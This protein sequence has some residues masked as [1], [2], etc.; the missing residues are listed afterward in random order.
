MTE[1]ER[2]V[3]ERWV[4]ERWGDET[5]PIPVVAER[6]AEETADAG[7]DG[8][9]VALSIGA[10]ALAGLALILLL[11][12]IGLWALYLFHDQ[13]A[14]PAPGAAPIVWT[15]T[16]SAV[17]TATRPPASTETPPPTLAPALEVGQYVQVIQ[18]G[19]Y[20]LNLRAGPG[21]DHEIVRVASDGEIFLAIE[22]PV[23]AD[24]FEWWRV[25]DPADASRAWWAV[26]DFLQTTSR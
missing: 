17:P 5:S 19:G 11:A 25:Q 4:N 13:I 7:R 21:T 23:D 24:E 6:S 18:T 20:G 16:P 26:G 2:G 8:S 3:N 1:N 12:L 15:P 9:A 10:W 22:G 14:E